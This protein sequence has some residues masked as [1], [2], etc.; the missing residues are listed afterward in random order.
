MRPAWSPDGR[1]IAF[2]SYHGDSEIYPVDVAT[3]KQ[4]QL[5]RNHADDVNPAWR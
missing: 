1:H 4:S 2:D 5:T 3:D